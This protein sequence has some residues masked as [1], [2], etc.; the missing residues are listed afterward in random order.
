MQDRRHRSVL[1]HAVRVLSMAESL[2]RYIEYGASVFALIDI[3]K[4]KKK[5]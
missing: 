4:S 2:Y 1:H 3:L 5:K